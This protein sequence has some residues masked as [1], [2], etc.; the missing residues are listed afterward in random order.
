MRT[1]QYFT[2]VY[3]VL[4]TTQ[5]QFRYVCA[6]H[7]PR[8]W[9]QA[10]AGDAARGSRPADRNGADIPYEEHVLELEAGDRLLLYS[11]A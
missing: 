11:D 5:R 2:M 7:P 8:S 4:D 6:G 1:G 9:P 10:R 3:G